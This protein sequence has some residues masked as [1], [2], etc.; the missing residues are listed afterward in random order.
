MQDV[1]S[2]DGGQGLQHLPS[3]SMPSTSNDMQAED[4][5]EPET[6]A[7]VEAPLNGRVCG[8]ACLGSYDPALAPEAPIGLIK[9]ES[10]QILSVKT[11]RK[12]PKI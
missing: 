4:E 1:A 9:K 2:Q 12:A 11:L 10:T 6:V 3:P 5:E 7:K 8:W